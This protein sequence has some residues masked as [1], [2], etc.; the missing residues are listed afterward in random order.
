MRLIARTACGLL[1]IALLGVAVGSSAQEAQPTLVPTSTNTPIPPTVDPEATPDPEATAE[2]TEE[3]IQLVI[4]PVEGSGI[5]P[6]LEMDLPE[7]WLVGHSTILFQDIDRYPLLPFSLYTGP[8]TGGQGFIVVLW[9]FSASAGLD[10]QFD[11]YRDGLRLLRLALLEPGCNLGTNPDLEMAFPIGELEGLGTLFT[12]IDCPTEPDTR[13]WYAVL[14]HDSIN[15][16]FFVYTEPLDIIDGPA[17]DEL[18]AILDTVEFDVPGL[19]DRLEALAA[20]AA[21]D[22]GLLQDITPEVTAAPESP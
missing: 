18:Q 2:V 12:A 4:E 14:R 1:L 15:F 6:P 19:I 8:V 21:Q 3:P 20:E 10:G 13:G 22:Q 17:E 7:D 5:E 11:L 16:A 9:G